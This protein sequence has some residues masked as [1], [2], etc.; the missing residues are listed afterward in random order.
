MKVRILLAAGLFAL[1]FGSC[2]PQANKEGM[3]DSTS[4]GSIHIS[5]DESFKPVIEEQIAMYENTYPDTK[6]I[7]TYK[8]EAECLKD[9]IKDTA[10]RMIIVTRQLNEKENR[11]F[12]DSLGY[13]PGSS[14]VATDAVAI[15][16][17]IT[18]TDTLF[19][20]Q[21]LHDQL[22]G[23]INRN[24]Q[25]VFDGLSATSTVRVITDSVLKGGRFDTSVVN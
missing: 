2:R 14:V 20:L 3:Y 24:Q 10:T 15:V 21:R 1:A 8:P 5:V 12:L 4:S 19:T 23:K 16:V 9:L 18:S 17:N 25:I 13:A 6:I 22:T 11:F 7:A